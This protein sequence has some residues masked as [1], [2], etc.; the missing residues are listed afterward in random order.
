MGSVSILCALIIYAIW[1]FRAKHIA[2]KMSIHPAVLHYSFSARQRTTAKVAVP[3]LFAGLV[4]A[5]SAFRFFVG[6]EGSR[7]GV[8][9]GPGGHP[10]ADYSVDILNLDK[11]SVAVH[12]ATTDERGLF[13]IDMQ[14]KLG[15]AAYFAIA[16][17]DGRCK[18]LKKL[19]VNLAWGNGVAEEGRANASEQS[20]IPH[21]TVD[22]PSY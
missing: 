21:L 9:V 2:C 19:P 22:C 13:V 20:R 12:A 3:F 7:E 1:V 16:S 14:R 17:A 15:R 11:E 10:L 4:F 6:F 18:S 5:A 8:L